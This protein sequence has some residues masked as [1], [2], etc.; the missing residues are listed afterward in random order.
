MTLRKPSHFDAFSEAEAAEALG[1]TIG[2][3]YQLLDEYI[4]NEGRHRPPHLE[5][6]SSDLVLLAY[7]NSECAVQPEA[8]LDNV[9]TIHTGS[10]RAP[11]RPEAKRLR[12]RSWSA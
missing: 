2:R 4:F 8:V 12:R 10:T 11:S 1:I 5:F 7:W 9:V 6:N 3:L